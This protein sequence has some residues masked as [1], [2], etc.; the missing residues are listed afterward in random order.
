MEFPI[1][2]NLTSPFPILGM[3]GDICY[4]FQISLEDY[5]SKQWRS[6]SAAS[7]LGLHCLPVSYKKDAIL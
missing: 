2:I 5:V 3:F 1:V 7:D 6:C 4:I